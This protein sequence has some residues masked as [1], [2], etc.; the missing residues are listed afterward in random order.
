MNE[1]A[2]KLVKIAK[3]ICGILNDLPSGVTKDQVVAQKT[4]T[5]TNSGLDMGQYEET[6]YVDLI[7][8]EKTENYLVFPG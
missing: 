7:V 3:E 1:M 8:Y 6:R 5:Y 4:G 2:K